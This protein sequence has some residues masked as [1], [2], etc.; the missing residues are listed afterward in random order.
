MNPTDTWKARLHAGLPLP[1][2]SGG[3]EAELP[4]EEVA[5]REAAARLG[6]AN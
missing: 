3:D 5:Y 2:I 1:P 4:A 6:E